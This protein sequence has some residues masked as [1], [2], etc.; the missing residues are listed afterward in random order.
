MFV[1][2]DAPS[3]SQ[4]SF[5]RFVNDGK[6]RNATR[7]DGVLG[8]KGIGSYIGGVNFMAGF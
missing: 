3:W 8:R 1:A 5:Q 6:R 7:C 4:T 2:R